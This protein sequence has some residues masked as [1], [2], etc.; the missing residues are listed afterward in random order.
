[1]RLTSLRM[2]GAEPAALVRPSGAVP[3]TALNDAFGTSWPATVQELLEQG[4]VE[5]A[6]RLG[7]R[8]RRGPARRPGAP[9]GPASPTRRS[10]AGPARSGG[11]G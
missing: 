8:R 3:L 4:Q 1:M 6:A 2:D 11:S 7:G 10:T 5:D 9:A